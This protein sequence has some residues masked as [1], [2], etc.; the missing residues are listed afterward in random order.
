MEKDG[1]RSVGHLRPA[2]NRY[3]CDDWG[4]HLHPNCHLF[5]FNPLPRPLPHSPAL[6]TSPATAILNTPRL[7]W[8]NTLDRYEAIG[9]GS[10][11]LRPRPS[12]GFVELIWHR[13]N[14]I[15]L[16]HMKTA[17][18]RTSPRTCLLTRHHPTGV[19]E[20]NFFN[21]TMEGAIDT[22]PKTLGHLLTPHISL[23]AF[24]LIVIFSLFVIVMTRHGMK[25][26]PLS[27]EV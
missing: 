12:L 9:R 19:E 13:R 10:L 21:L 17:R 16:L 14:W 27:W 11:S 23:I 25:R 2:C 22:R 24:G 26:G 7:F 4:W 15:F 1:I 18:L 20:N 8:S 3:V 5:S 6:L